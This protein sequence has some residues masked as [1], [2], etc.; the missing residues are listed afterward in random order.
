VNG[1]KDTGFGVRAPQPCGTASLMFAC[2]Y[3]MVLRMACAEAE[4]TEAATR[5][6]KMYR[7][8]G[9][10]LNSPAQL[11][12]LFAQDDPVRAARRI[13]QTIPLTSY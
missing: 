1:L 7:A 6:V 12:K 8:W 9:P 4:A 10:A 3:G 2:R 11:G 13:I 5:L